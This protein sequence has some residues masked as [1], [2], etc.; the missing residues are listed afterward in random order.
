MCAPHTIDKKLK[1]YNL[2]EDSLRWIEDYLTYR[3]HYVS[4]GR[5]NSKMQSVGRGVPQGSVL[6]PLL[7]SV[8]TNDITESIREQDCQ[9]PAHQ[10]TEK[11][12][13]EDCEECGVLIV[14][15]DDTNYRI[16]NKFR[17]SNQMKLKKKLLDIK[18]YL[19]ANDLVINMDK[20]V[21]TECMV[22]QKRGRLGGTPPE[23][24]VID[25]DGNNKMITDSQYCKILGGNIQNNLSWIGHLENA[26]KAIL[27]QIRK[28]LGLLKSL[29]KTLPKNCRNTLARGMVVSKLI[30]LI[31]IWG[32]GTKNHIRKAQILLNNAARWAACKPKGTKI[33]SLMEELD[34]M[35]IK[36]MTVQNSSTLMW[37]MLNC[38]KPLRIAENITVDRTRMI[39][40]ITEPR[41]Q[42][43][44]QNFTIRAGRDWNKLPDHIR[45]NDKLHIFKKQVKTWIK[46]QR[47]PEPD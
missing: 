6:G 20:T 4:I 11:L 1:L 27:P 3:S 12:F 44:E 41:L 10:N 38:R 45:L 31:S 33:A 7:Y 37:K 15:A 25:K 21:L 19:N 22:K 47:N 43:T 2:D 46:E 42:I 18:E 39:I 34:W 23:L 32:G 13:G 24:E 29:G 14:Y 9:S 36:E 5:A 30:Y 40:N 16:S 8:Y 17:R 35:T 26:E 28:N